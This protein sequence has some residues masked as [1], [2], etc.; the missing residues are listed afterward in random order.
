MRYYKTLLKKLLVDFQQLS[1][2]FSHEHY[3]NALIARNL[4]KANQK[5]LGMLDQTLVRDCIQFSCISTS[6]KNF[7]SGFRTLVFA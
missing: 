2:V 3:L 1:V 4:S 5:R 6:Q 7:L